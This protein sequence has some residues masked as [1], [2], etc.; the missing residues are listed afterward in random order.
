M[1]RERPWPLD[2]LLQIQAMSEHFVNS[3][4]LPDNHPGTSTYRAIFLSLYS[5]GGQD[6]PF[7]TK[8]STNGVSR[9]LC[10]TNHHKAINEALSSKLI[11]PA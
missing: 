6:D 7:L 3:V 10:D 2:H 5:S 8:Y 4:R 11:S 1:K 9:C